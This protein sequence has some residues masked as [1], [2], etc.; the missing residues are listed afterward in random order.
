[1][2]GVMRRSGDVF[3]LPQTQ[4]TKL[5]LD[6][7]ASALTEASTAEGNASYAAMGEGLSFTTA[8]FAAATEY[9]GYVA[10]R[11]NVASST[12]DLDLFATLRLIDPSGKEMF[13]TGAHEPVQVARGWLRASH[14]RVDPTRSKPY[15]PIRP[16]DEIQKLE[17]GE[18]YPLDIEIWPTSIVVPAGYRLMLTITGRDLEVPGI[19][20]RLLHNDPADRGTQEFN[21]IGTLHTGGVRECYLLMPRIPS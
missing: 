12:T 10:L 3:P 11:L 14:R 5:Y 6:A 8:P 2:D 1:I 13:F 19:P 18:I 16:H 17:P 9:S 20:G 4:W 7:K 21:G 15:L